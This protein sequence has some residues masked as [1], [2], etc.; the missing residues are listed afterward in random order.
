M[1]KSEKIVSVLNLEKYNPNQY[2]MKFGE[3][4]D[5]FY[6]V[7][8]GKGALYKPI[9]NR[10]EMTL[11]KYSDIMYDIKYH[12]L[13]KLKYDRMIEKNNHLIIDV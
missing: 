1:S 4:G 2:I 10:K 9:Y 12:E 11:Q 6:I 8:K 5:K 13:D 3:E 7:L